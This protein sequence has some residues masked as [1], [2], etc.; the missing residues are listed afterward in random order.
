MLIVL[1]FLIP[2]VREEPFP[3]SRMMTLKN[4]SL[5]FRTG[6]GRYLV[7]SF[8]SFLVIVLFNNLKT[9]TLFLLAWFN[10]VLIIKGIE[11]N[12]QQNSY[13]IFPPTSA[14]TYL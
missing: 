5:F 10:L 4:L 3:G 6:Q 7:E 8:R 2:G 13:N 1:P 9:R 11:E 12:W 14:I